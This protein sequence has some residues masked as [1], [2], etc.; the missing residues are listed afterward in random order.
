ML[1]NKDTMKKLYWNK[2]IDVEQIIIDLQQ[3]NIILATSDTVLGLLSIV[4]PTCFERLNLL[5][6]RDQKPYLLL[7]GTI[8]RARSCINQSIWRA[9]EPLV[10]ACWPGPLTILVPASEL[11][12]PY[13]TNGHHVIGIRVPRHAGLQSVLE[14]IEMLFSTSANISGRE[15]PS[16]IGD[17]DEKLL[18][19]S[20][21]IVLDDEREML[22]GEPSTII[23]CT[24]L[25]IRVVR[26][27]AYAI[28]DLEAICS[29]SMIQK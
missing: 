29:P 18:H 28:A 17:V 3:E 23:D 10:M 13:A 21:Y 16:G 11:I 8:E 6:R 14:E 26:E 15:V 2:A 19:A 25:P 1:K 24:S 4:T 9:I 22:K 20:G 12:P 7:T 27:G 5:K